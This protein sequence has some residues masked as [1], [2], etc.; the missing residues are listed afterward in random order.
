MPAPLLNF[1]PPKTWMPQTL[2]PSPVATPLGSAT[3]AP[4]PVV[5]TLPKTQPWR[6]S[7]PMTSRRF[8]PH[9]TPMPPRCWTSGL[10]TISITSTTSIWCTDR[11]CSLQTKTCTHMKRLA[12][13]LRALRR[14]RLCS[15]KS[16]CMLCWRWGSWAC[17]RARRVKFV[18]TARW[19]TPITSNWR[20]WWKRTRKLLLN[21]KDV[22]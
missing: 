14:M 18:P 16:L 13:L 20:Q 17:W 10:P 12:A 8:V 22:W 6:K 9:Q 4:S 11:A 2:W 21:F 15:T 7:L 3:A 1:S 19:G 5:S